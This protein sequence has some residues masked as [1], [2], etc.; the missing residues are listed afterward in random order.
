[1][2]F[3]PVAMFSALFA[4]RSAPVL[5]AAQGRTLSAAWRCNQYAQ[6]LSSW[7]VH[8]DDEAPIKAGG[9]HYNV[10]RAGGL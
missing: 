1:M 7:A 2:T 3:A 5:A 4:V 8:L 10:N 9:G 6:Q